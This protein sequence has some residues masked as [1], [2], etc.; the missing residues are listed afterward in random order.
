MAASESIG[1]EQ[2][3][4]AIPLAVRKDGDEEGRIFTLVITGSLIIFAR[5]T[6]EDLSRIG[7]ASETILMGGAILDPERHRKTLGSYSRRY[8]SMEPTSV[9]EESAENI[10][11]KTADVTAIRISSEED[12]EGDQFYL[13]AFETKAGPRKYLIPSDKDS[14]DLLISTF[15]QKVHW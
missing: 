15:G 14:R 13:L 11:M 8:L 9:V 2:V 4:G 12:A 5:T 1:Q 3:E 7:K 6:E 10:Y